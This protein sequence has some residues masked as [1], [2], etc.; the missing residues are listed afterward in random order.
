MSKDRN[1]NNR[2]LVAL[3][4]QEAHLGTPFVFSFTTKNSFI[5]LIIFISPMFVWGKD[6]QEQAVKNQ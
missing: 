3:R 2:Y 5:Q 1:S 6:G 4:P